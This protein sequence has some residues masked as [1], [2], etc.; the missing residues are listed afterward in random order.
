MYCQSCGALATQGLNYCKQCGANLAPPSATEA[1][2][3]AP[4]RLSS[5]IWALSAFGIFGLG[6]LFGG[7]IALTALH[8]SG[9]LVG[10]T[11]FVGTFSIVAIMAMLIRLLTKLAGIPRKGFTPP[12]TLRPPGKKEFEAPRTIAP[13]SIPASSVTEHTTRTF[14]ERRLREPAP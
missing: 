10:F 7:L 4:P 3:S 12:I 1:T 6:A 8:A 2:V 13:P 9:D 5:M 11:A 14:H